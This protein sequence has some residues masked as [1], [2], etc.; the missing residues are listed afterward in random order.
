MSN[1]IVIRGSNEI[2]N[3]F[4]S[5]TSRDTYDCANGAITQGNSAAPISLDSCFQQYPEILKI[6]KAIGFYTGISGSSGGN[7]GGAQTG[8]CGSSG[9]KGYTLWTGNPGGSFAKGLD[10]YFNTTTEEVNLVAKLLGTGWIGCLWGTPNASYSSNC[11]NV[12]PYYEAYIKHRLNDASFWN[13][14]VQTP[15]KRA[16]FVDALQYGRKV[17]VTIAGDFNLNLGEVINLRVNSMSGY[18]YSSASSY[19]NGYYYITGIKHVV[20]NSGTHET[21]LALSQIAGVSGPYYP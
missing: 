2:K 15:V 21:A 12:G 11:P 3:A 5:V 16:E 18:P 7:G 13:T 10:L 1:Q 8:N 6:A 4:Y 14:P 20:T 17:D 19:M 9:Y